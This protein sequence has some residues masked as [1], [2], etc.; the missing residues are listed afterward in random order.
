[1]KYVYDAMGK[2]IAEYA[3]TPMPCVTCYFAVDH[4]GSTR[5]LTDALGVVI[6]RHDYLPFGEE[7]FAG[8]GGRTA[9]LTGMKFPN[10]NGDGLTQKFTG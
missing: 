3:G 4:L 10:A 7:I 8:V 1:M 9:G 6:E 5:A 2:L